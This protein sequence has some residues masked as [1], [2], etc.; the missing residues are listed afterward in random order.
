M[1]LLSTLPVML[2]DVQAT[3][4]SPPKGNLLDLAWCP[5]DAQTPQEAVDAQT[6]GSLVQ[7]QT[8]SRIP[9]RITKL[10][11]I[12]TLMLSDGLPIQDVAAM[13]EEA[14]EAAGQPVAVAHYARFERPY[15]ELLL[16][17]DVE[18]ICTHEI[19]KR[20][21]PNLPRRGLRPLAGYFGKVPQEVKRASDHVRATALIWRELVDLLA[22]EEEILTLE[23]L[24][25]WLAQTKSKRATKREFPLAREVRLGLPK[26]PGVYRMLSR[27]GTVLY[28][29]KATNLKQR[30]NSY[31]RGRKGVAEKTLELVTQVW[32]LDVTEVGSPFE[33]AVLEADEIKRL[34]PP[35]NVLLKRQDRH[36]WFA[37]PDDP[38]DLQNAP[39]LTHTMGPFSG[40]SAIERAGHILRC[41]QGQSHPDIG[42][43]FFDIG[44]DDD[45]FQ[46]GI[47]LFLEWF[48]IEDPINWTQDEMF[49]LGKRLWLERL[50][51]L[52]EQANKAQQEVDE[53][54]IEQDLEDLE[55]A[56]DED[57]EWTPEIVAQGLKQHI[58]TYYK[59]V[60]RA[61]CLMLL[62]DATIT[63]HPTFP[64]DAEPQSLTLRQGQL[65]PQLPASPADP[66]AR[67]ACVDV[68]TYD[69]LKVVLGEVRRVW[70]AQ[71][72][73]SMELPD[74]TRFEREDLAAILTISGTTI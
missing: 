28:V 34:D 38:L 70:S 17:R 11:G 4:P 53:E 8:L 69:R 40:T 47:D 68:D 48:R 60:E 25:Q 59:R 22:K 72:P 18:M 1:T 64:A 39:D 46:Q 42:D 31:F 73:I 35:Y 56:L 44:A 50:A 61:R 45:V 30:V 36:I 23:Q 24:R 21:L 43:I 12:T 26:A 58:M 62:L 65:D 37:C 49:A 20:L 32:D 9:S 67:L 66:I 3:G 27:T 57:F 5:V 51:W 13:F 19:A 55:E 29:G 14:V 33:A 10:T 16:G 52:V 6:Q 7:L 74:G 41:I 63:W 15:L 2:V 54:A 71:G